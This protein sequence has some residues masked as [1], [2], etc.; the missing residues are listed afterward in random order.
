M[1]QIK[2]YSHEQEDGIGDLVKS[3]ASIAYCSLAKA[4]TK[5]I[6]NID[7]AKMRGIAD[8]LINSKA[9]N[10]DQADL[11]YLESVLVSTG[12]NKND[13]VFI[14][15]KTWAARNTPEDKQFNFMHNENDIIGHITGSYVTDQD[16][17][18]IEGDIMPST[19]DIVTQA[20]IYNSWM[21][22][23]NKARMEKTIAEIEEDKWFVS[24]ECLF[25]NF[26]Y[27]LIDQDGKSQLLQRT[28]ATSFLTKHLRIYGGEGSYEG[29]KIGRALSDFSFSG[30]GLVSNPANPRSV[31]L[32]GKS[33]AF[34]ANQYD[35]SI[36]FSIGEST[37]SDPKES[38]ALAL[39]QEAIAKLTDQLDALKNSVTA[40]KIAT[41]EASAVAQDALV[42]SLTTDLESAVK[43]SEAAVAKQTEVEATLT[44][45]NEKLEVATKSLAEIE[46]AKVQAIRLLALTEAGLEEEDAQASLVSFADLSDDAFAA[47][48]ASLV[49]AG[50][51]KEDESDDDKKK[52]ADKAKKDAEAAVLA[53]KEAEATALAVKLAEI[54]A[55]KADPNITPEALADLKTAEAELN[56]SNE[57]ESQKM[58]SEASAW[59][60]KTLAK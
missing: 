8:K 44:E 27:A 18:V 55:A 10:V 23:S 22:D 60:E 17:K 34:A 46:T 50:F 56:G 25:S 58:R 15:E 14:P 51:K 4:G 48:I 5:N 35:N 39:A 20:V 28:E 3:S 29:Y 6:D 7:D 45:A 26:D 24:M 33:L 54:E 41:L 52:K 49:K 12:W 11:Y 16:G 2:V 38:A 9:E 36:P 32:N 13:D 30:K 37:M 19:F 57:D 53:K 43:A 1:T 47:V 42:V 40:E 59:F 21:D 31:I